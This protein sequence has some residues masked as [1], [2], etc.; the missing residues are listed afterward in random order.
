M[1][2]GQTRSTNRRG[3]DVK[4]GGFR[5]IH[6]YH[7]WGTPTG[8]S[9]YQVHFGGLGTESEL[10]GVCTTTLASENMKEGDPTGEGSGYVVW[11]VLKKVDV[12][13]A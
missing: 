11:S 9:H 10:P 7:G 5:P 6:H 13:C 8:P 3:T 12:C 4:E 2:G 1:I